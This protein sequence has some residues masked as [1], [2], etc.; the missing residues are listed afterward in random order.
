MNPSRRRSCAYRDSDRLIILD[1]AQRLTE[2]SRKFLIDFDATRTPIALLGNPEI[3]QQFSATINTSAA[4]RCR[5]ITLSDAEHAAEVNKKTVLTLLKTCF[6]R[7]LEDKARQTVRLKCSAL[8]TAVP[9]A[10][11]ATCSA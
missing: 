3:V 7:L 11:C 1:N 10:P 9:H 8:R 2:R 5:N 4:G 6:P